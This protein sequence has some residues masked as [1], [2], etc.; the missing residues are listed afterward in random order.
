M[1]SGLTLAFPLN[2]HQLVHGWQ[3]PTI[4]TVTLNIRGII[5]SWH[6]VFPALKELFSSLSVSIYIYASWLVSMNRSLLHHSLPQDYHKSLGKY[7]CHSNPIFA[8]SVQETAL[9]STVL[10]DAYSSILGNAVFSWSFS[11]FAWS[12]SWWSFDP[13]RDATFP[14][15]CNGDAAFFF[16]DSF[17]LPRHSNVHFTR[18]SWSIIDDFTADCVMFKVLSVVSIQTEQRTLLYKKNNSIRIL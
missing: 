1:I 12:M 9:S 17:K 15:R 4:V 5:G 11:P 14:K 10:R 13:A 7:D 3:T 6:F 18:L 2:G 8:S 16:N